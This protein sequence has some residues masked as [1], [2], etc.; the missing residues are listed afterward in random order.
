MRI[1]DTIK[2]DLVTA[3]KAKDATR[4]RVLRS[5]KA[6]LLEKQISVREGGARDLTDQEQVDVL[7]KAAKQRKDS[8]TQYRE[9]NRP[10]LADIEE[11]ELRIIETYLPRMMDAQEI[12]EAVQ[13]LLAEAGATGMGDMGRVMGLAMGRYKG[14]ADPAALSAA[15][16]A[17]L[18]SL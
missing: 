10:D 12:E 17:A 13:S 3:M 16:K 7:M 18:S 4:L 1:E 9:G 6:K 5:L 11:A 15:V 14:K 2:K 8:A